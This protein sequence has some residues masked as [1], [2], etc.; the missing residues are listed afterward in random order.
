MRIDCVAAFGL[1][2]GPPCIR[3]VDLELEIAAAYVHLRTDD[4]LDKR[5]TS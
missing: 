1:F 4:G 2:G 3:V 5:Q